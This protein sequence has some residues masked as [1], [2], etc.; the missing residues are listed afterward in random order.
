MNIVRET[1]VWRDIVNATPDEKEVYGKVSVNDYLDL[2]RK[3][4]AKLTRDVAPDN[5][6]KLG[7]VLSEVNEI[8]A[9]FEKIVGEI[10]TVRVQGNGYYMPETGDDFYF[11]E[12]TQGISG[13]FAGFSIQTLPT[14]RD[15]L[16]DTDE[17]YTL[18]PALCLELRDY[19]TYSD[20]GI[21]LEP[22]EER[23]NAIIPLNDQDLA[24][25]RVP[26]DE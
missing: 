11:F 20:T 5:L 16:S 8:V 18:V 12:G 7:K 24:Y 26:T 17:A 1:K 9:E 6:E 23:G 4:Y 3:Y 15:L 10:G 2:A 22:D 14:Y 19:R 21:A 25:T 13:E